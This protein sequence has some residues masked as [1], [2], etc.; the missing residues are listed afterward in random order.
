MIPPCSLLCAGGAALGLAV[1]LGTCL[2]YLLSPVPLGASPPVSVQLG[3]LRYDIVPIDAPSATGPVL[4][5]L[6]ALFTAPP[7][8]PLL[9]RGLLNQNGVWKL[10]ELARQVPD[11]VVQRFLPIQRLSQ[12][13]MERH[14]H[15]AQQATSQGALLPP[16]LSRERAQSLVTEPVYWSIE[17]YANAYQRGVSP[18]AVVTAILDAIPRAEAAVGR[19]FMQISS[20]QVQKQA[21]ESES[22]WQNGIPRSVFEGVPVAIK[23]MIAVLGHTMRDGSSK[24]G[25]QVPETA[26]DPIVLRLRAAGAIIIG[27]TVMTEFGVTPLGWSAHWRGP[28]NPHSSVPHYPGGSSSGS[29]VAV[30]TG[31]VP[32]A[33]GF[34]GGGSIRI[35][36]ALSGV[37]GLACGFDRVRF[38]GSFGSESSMVHAGPIATSARDI[39]LGYMLIASNAPPFTPGDCD[40]KDC[41]WAKT[42]HIVSDGLYGGNGPPPAHLDGWQHKPANLS[43]VRLGVFREHFEDATP[44]VLAAAE[45]ALQRLRANG[46]VIVDL[47]IPNMH[48]LSV[49]HGM[50]ISAEF[51]ASHDRE[52]STHTSGTQSLE[53][54][55]RIQLA[56]GSAMTGAEF[57]ATSRLRSWA[58]EYVRDK[59]FRG[60]NIDALVSPTVGMQA[61]PLPIAAQR[62]GESNTA[63]VVS[64]CK[65]I[66]LANLLGLPALSV[67]LQP[68]PRAGS[69]AGGDGDGIHTLPTGLQFMGSWWNE[70]TILRLARALEWAQNNDGGSQPAMSRPEQY[71][72]NALDN[73]LD[74]GYRDITYDA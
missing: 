49:A 11:S 74:P 2:P 34:D 7:V 59:I 58:F 28:T 48:A 69:G 8:G 19:V 35:P 54:S 10:R 25:G 32:L 38:G 12:P 57:L 67:P 63:L 71:F 45:A 6:A 61:P 37:F 68:V 29:A 55:T 70:S 60:Q 27:T 52:F 1:L 26:D 13:E 62:S 9:V 18:V 46:A 42:D 3:D 50:A 44:P 24:R 5:A 16:S 23:D 51:I 14:E 4:S 64:L 40:T 39:A 20:A 73:I 41:A 66:F 56:L 33:I 17:D 30:A 43:G 31:L 65:H 72:G 15:L 36:A 53:P 22:R 47:A 21:A